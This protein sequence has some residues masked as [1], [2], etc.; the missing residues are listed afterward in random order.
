M[1]TEMGLAILAGSIGLGFSNIEKISRFKGAGFEAEMRMVQ[2]IIESQTEPSNEQQESAKK[3]ASISDT[4]NRIL[5]SLQKPSYTWRYAKT[6]AGETSLTEKE[7]EST[8]SSLMTR[9]L[10][11]SGQG[12][13]GEI[14]AATAL[15]KSIQEK[16][17]VINAQSIHQTGR[18]K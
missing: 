1:P 12:T 10:T 3:I 5:K 9:G 16:Y 17:E 13:N 8:L 7:V 6:V 18:A 14:W 2:T 4:E 11:K 15:G